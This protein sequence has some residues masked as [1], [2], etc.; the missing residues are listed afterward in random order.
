MTSAGDAPRSWIEGD[1]IYVVEPHADDAFLSLGWSIRRWVKEGRTVEVVTVYSAAEGRA[2][3]AA[4]WAKSV[5]AAWSG[6]GHE[7]LRVEGIKL[8]ESVPPLPEPLLPDAMMRLGACRI[9]PLGLPHPEHRAVA[10]AA[11]DGELHYV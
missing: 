6:L 2:R 3:E 8:P 11:P 4:M 9:W 5:G 7:G 1:P 10:A